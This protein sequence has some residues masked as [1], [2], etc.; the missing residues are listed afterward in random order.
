MKTA[1]MAREMAEA[2]LQAMHYDQLEQILSL[3]IFIQPLVPSDRTWQ[4]DM[5]K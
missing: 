5:A 1:N 2:L 3:K 4:F